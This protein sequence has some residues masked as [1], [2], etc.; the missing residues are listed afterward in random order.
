MV[1]LLKKKKNLN[2]R[3]KPY[4]HVRRK[5]RITME[6]L[7]SFSKVS[8]SMKILKLC[9]LLFSLK[10]YY[11]KYIVFIYCIVMKYK[12]M[13]KNKNG[14]FLC[15][16][17]LW[18]LFCII[19]PKWK[20]WDGRGS[21]ATTSICHVNVHRKKWRNQLV[22]RKESERC[23]WQYIVIED[24]HCLILCL[25]VALPFNILPDGR[26]GFR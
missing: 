24:L 13:N 14:S 1:K 16:L 3:L 17:C 9:L 6:T 5:H 4:T 8:M 25:T 12:E 19:K 10:N 26:F 2:C 15:S 11:W 22:L 18:K 23:Q 7:L 21:T 20:G